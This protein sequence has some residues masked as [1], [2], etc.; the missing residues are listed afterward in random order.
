MGTQIQY[1]NINMTWR[2]KY[3]MVTKILQLKVACTYFSWT[4]FSEP[5]KTFKQRNIFWLR[6][7]LEQKLIIGSRN[8]FG[9]CKIW[10]DKKNLVLEKSPIEEKIWVE[11]K[12]WVESWV[13]KK[14][15]QVKKNLRVERNF[16]VKKYLSQEHLVDENSYPKVPPY[17]QI[18]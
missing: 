16:G 10:V 13:R 5:R 4:F 2:N 3:N 8:L 1:G 6:K 7:F 17:N 14:K 9:S 15:I 18:V 11:K 12:I